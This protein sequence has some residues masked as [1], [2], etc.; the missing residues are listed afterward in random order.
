MMSSAEM[1]SS[2][3]TTVA[4]IATSGIGVGIPSIAAGGV[5]HGGALTAV[6]VVSGI[7]TVVIHLVVVCIRRIWSM[8]VESCVQCR[9]VSASFLCACV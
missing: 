1:T 3:T 9:A 4:L 5:F 8:A 2:T 6:D 7:S